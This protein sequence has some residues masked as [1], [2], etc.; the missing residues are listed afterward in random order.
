[1]RDDDL[2]CSSALLVQLQLE[3]L[4]VSLLHEMGRPTRNSSLAGQSFI[5]EGSKKIET[6]KHQTV[7]PD[8]HPGISTLPTLLQT[9]ISYLLTS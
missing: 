6:P 2:E 7:G 8:A 9:C 5:L 3:A 1:M 4:M